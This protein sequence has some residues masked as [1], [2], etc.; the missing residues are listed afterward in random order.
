MLISHPT[1][2]EL[3]EAVSVMLGG[4]GEPAFARRL[5]KNAVDTVAREL[6]LGPAAEQRAAARLQSLTGAEGSFDH[7]SAQLVQEIRSGKLADDDPALLDH[8]RRTALDMLAI[9]QPRYAHGLT[10]DSHD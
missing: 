8:C 5:A 7:L 4:A 10:R 6:A 2:A 3:L 9:D 1:A